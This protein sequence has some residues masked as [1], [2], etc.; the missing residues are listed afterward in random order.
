METG[1]GTHIL[2]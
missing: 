2:M 1:E